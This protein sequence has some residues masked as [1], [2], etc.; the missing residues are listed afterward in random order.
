MTLSVSI[1]WLVNRGPKAAA[2]AFGPATL[3][4]LLLLWLMIITTLWKFGLHLPDLNLRA[5]SPAYLNFTLS[6]YSRLLAL[7]T[8]IEVFA[9][10]VAAYEGTPKRRSQLAFRSLLI[11]MGTTCVTMLIVGPAIL[12]LSN[13]AQGQVSVFTQTM[14]KLLPRP[15]RIWER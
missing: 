2:R 12:K 15:C 10:L 14:D 8:G 3:G 1:A 6:G 13:P 4:V 9:N 5:F 11:A 7:M